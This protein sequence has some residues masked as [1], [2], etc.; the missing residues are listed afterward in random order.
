MRSTIPCQRVRIRV[1]RIRRIRR[2]DRFGRVRSARRRARKARPKKACETENEIT[3]EKRRPNGVFGRRFVEKNRKRGYRVRVERG[4]TQK[5]L[6]N[7]I[8]FFI[9]PLTD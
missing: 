8:D 7:R 1:G 5:K 4:K 2:R 9:K 6:Q 3:I